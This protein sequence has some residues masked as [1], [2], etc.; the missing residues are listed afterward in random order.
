MTKEQRLE[1]KTRVIQFKLRYEKDNFKKQIL[2][3]KLQNAHL[4]LSV[5]CR[6]N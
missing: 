1:L 2:V 5:V 4:Q 3:R 6:M